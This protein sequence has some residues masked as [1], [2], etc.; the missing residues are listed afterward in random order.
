MTDFYTRN[1]SGD[2]SYDSSTNRYVS[3]SNPTTT[4]TVSK[5]SRDAFLV[6]GSIQIQPNIVKVD[7]NNIPFE[8]NSMAGAFCDPSVYSSRLNSVSNINQNVTNMWMTFYGCTN[9]VNTPVIPN[10]VVN[11]DYTFESCSNLVNAPIIPNSVTSMNYTFYGCSN[12]VNAPAIPNSVTTMWMTFSMCYNLVNAPVIPNSVTFMSDTFRSCSSLV[13]APVI[14][15]SVTYMYGT[16]NGCSSL[17]NAPAIP[18]SVTDMR[19]TFNGCSNLVN[20][21][22]IPN[23]VTNMWS[24]FSR[25]SNLIGDIYIYSNQ[26]SNATDCFYNTSLTKNVHI[27]FTYGNNINTRTYNSFIAAGYDTLG[28]TDGVYLKNLTINNT[29]NVKLQLNV[30]DYEYTSDNNDNITL[31]KYIGTNVDVIAPELTTQ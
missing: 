20:A 3:V 11:M 4:Y 10:S 7:L 17:V 6:K 30:E 9:L 29:T 24:T 27:P 19:R 18:N 1:P 26:V 16:F 14:P 22:V 25:C 13:N 12:L 21:P 31:T 15:N 5:I 28:T 8:D 23:S 2:L